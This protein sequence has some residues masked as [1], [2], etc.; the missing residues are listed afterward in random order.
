MGAL[1]MYIIIIIILI[2]LVA[3]VVAVVISTTSI[4]SIN[5]TLLFN[6]YCDG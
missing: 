6:V 4:D 2:V 1:Q 5:I 3:V